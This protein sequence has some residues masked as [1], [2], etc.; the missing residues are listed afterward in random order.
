[1]DF[2]HFCVNIP[3]TLQ[4]EG[5]TQ[6]KVAVLSNMQNI[7][8]AE[9]QLDTD[10]AHNG[11]ARWRKALGFGIFDAKCAA[12]LR[13]PGTAI[14]RDELGKNP[15]GEHLLVSVEPTVRLI[16]R[17]DVSRASQ[18]RGHRDAVESVG[19]HDAHA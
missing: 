17:D 13:L 9:P 1:V 18:C 3:L 5:I 15:L 14:L 16:D 19:R 11:I 2:V 12:V 10:D 4:R 7:S 6:R 8:K